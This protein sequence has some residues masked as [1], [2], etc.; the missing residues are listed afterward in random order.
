MLHFWDPCMQ[1]ACNSHRGSTIFLTE[2]LQIIYTVFCRY[3]CIFWFNIARPKFDIKKLGKLCV[4]LQGWRDGLI[5]SPYGTL[6]DMHPCQHDRFVILSLHDSGNSGPA[7]VVWDKVIIYESQYQC[8]LSNVMEVF[9]YVMKLP[10]LGLKSTNVN[11]PC[12][13]G[14]SAYSC[15]LG[16]V[17]LRPCSTRRTS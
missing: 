1:T 3:S 15:S 8:R 2:L 11:F 12:E 5:Y 16:L 7:I 4:S 9:P 6:S 10:F 17:A 14:P 13:S